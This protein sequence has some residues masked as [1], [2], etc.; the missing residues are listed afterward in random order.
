[1]P[2]YYTLSIKKNNAT[3]AGK[4]FMKSARAKPTL[5]QIFFFESFI[6]IRDTHIK[7]VYQNAFSLVQAMP[8]HNGSMMMNLKA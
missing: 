6:K 2:I 3:E 8:I 5:L 7:M 1:M 4:A